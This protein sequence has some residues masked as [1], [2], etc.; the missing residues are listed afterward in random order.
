MISAG[1]ATTLG[2]VTSAKPV[3]VSLKRPVCA[4]KGWNVA[5]S[6]RVGNRWRLIGYGKII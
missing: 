3:K 4:E 6:R 5:I 1:T 2:T